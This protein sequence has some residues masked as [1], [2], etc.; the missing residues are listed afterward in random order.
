MG[1]WDKKVGERKPGQKYGKLRC[2]VRKVRRILAKL[3]K[4]AYLVSVKNKLQVQ[5]SRQ[6]QNHTP[7]PGGG[8]VF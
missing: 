3:A 5:M 6:I 4:C 2:K 1:R 8:F 7:G